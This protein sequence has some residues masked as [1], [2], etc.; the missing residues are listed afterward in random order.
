MALYVMVFSQPAAAVMPHLAVIAL[1]LIAT[2]LVRVMLSRL[3]S[4]QG[5]NHLTAS[6]LISLVLTLLIT[7][8][9]LI[10]ISLA[11]WGGVPSL[12]AIPTFLRQSETAADTLHVPSLLIDVAPILV[13]AGFTWGC[14][15]Y[16]IRFDWT[17]GWVKAISNWTVAAIVMGGS[18]ILAIS[19]ID[20]SFGAGTQVSEPISLT[21]FSHRDSLDLEGYTVNPVVAS[22]VDRATALARSAYV[23]S[24]SAD[25]KNIVL[26]VVDALRPDHMGIYG[27]GRDTTPNLAR[28]S[29]EVPTRIIQ[30]THA[31][32]GDTACAMFSL[33]SSKFPSEFSFHPFFLHEALRRD[34]YKMRLILSGD[35]TFFFGMK[36][37]YGPVEGFYDGGRG[38]GRS[39]NDDQQV[40][41]QLALLPNWDGTPVMFQF[42]LMSAHVLR[43]AQRDPGPF[44]PAARYGLEASHDIG[45]GGVPKLSAVNF[46]DNGVLKADSVVN[47]LLSTLQSKAYLRNAVVVITADHGEALGEHGLFK[48]ANSVREE[49]LSIPLIL[50]YYGCQPRVPERTRAYPSQVDIAPTIL[51]ELALPIP[52]VWVGLPLQMPRDRDFSFFVEHAFAGLID[53]RDPSHIWKYWSDRHTGDDHVFDLNTDPHEDHDLRDVIPSYQLGALRARL[54]A[55]TASDL[56]VR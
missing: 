42:H 14:Y 7:Y 47:S 39:L 19:L 55:E 3:V 24:R 34:G 35:H 43:S 52:S 11:S 17:I 8:Y 37:F 30:G 1:P 44:I 51:T 9:A 29:R 26:I 16:L 2:L 45:P 13:F 6:L 15:L 50:L 22:R 31:S 23:P 27:Y 36:N 25:P 4:S 53:H 48:H 38:D 5:V 33:F 41:D 56:A 20:F 46:Y 49:L 10:L 40:L 21:I 32:C 28:L 18:A 12:E 54:R